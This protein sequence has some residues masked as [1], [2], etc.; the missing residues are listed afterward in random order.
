[1]VYPTL[2]KTRNKLKIDWYRSEIKPDRFRELSQKNNLKGWVQAGGHLLLFSSTSAAVYFTFEAKAWLIFFVTL[3]IHGTISSFLR[4]TASH[5][6][7]HGTVF[8]TKWLN[9]VFLYLFSLLSWWNP[10]DYAS[11]HTYHHRYTLHPEGDRENLLPL[12]PKIGK[13]FLLQLFTINLFTLPGRTFG[14]GGLISTIWVTIL[15][16]IGKTRSNDIPSNEWLNA[17][18]SDQPDQHKKSIYWSRIQLLFHG[19]VLI[20]SMVSG[21]WVLILIFT[22]CS[23]IGNWLSY[24]VSLPQHCGLQENVSDFRKSTRSIM[25]PRFIE[26][27]YW[28]MNWHIEHH[29][30]AG[31]PCYNLRELHKELKDDMP[32][33]RTLIGA[34]REMLD[35]WEKQKTD[36]SYQYDT[37][38]PLTAK[39][40][41][42]RRG[43]FAE[44]S[45]GDL[46]PKGL[47]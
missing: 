19:S 27:L 4:G 37:P 18:H 34:W 14:K 26:F 15:D 24:F 11:S 20:F 43:N 32:Y 30:Y 23:F 47:S 17:L 2:S 40:S 29:M 28:H 13:T 25:L 16:A 9:K 3:F 33:P 35:T 8:N 12:H 39:L 6:L 7:G 45:I 1:M 36:K 38:L 21:I 44:N 41:R 31:I 10:F 5:E 22:F 42:N 46:A